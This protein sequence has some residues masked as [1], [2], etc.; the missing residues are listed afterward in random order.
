MWL[1]DTTGA[2][3]ELLILHLPVFRFQQ[4]GSKPVARLVY[5]KNVKYSSP[6]ISFDW[7]TDNSALL[8]TV[9][10]K[11]VYDIVF[12]KGIHS[13]ASVGSVRLFDLRSLQPSTILYESCNFTSLRSKMD[14]LAAIMMDSHTMTILDVRVPA[15]PVAVLVFA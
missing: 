4:D 14:N 3:P 9:R 8:S 15:I 7:N 12:S 5:Q 2:K 10:D 6:L 1:P 13:F 11:E